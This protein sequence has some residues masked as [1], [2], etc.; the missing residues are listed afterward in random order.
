MRIVPAAKSK[1]RKHASN[2]GGKKSKDENIA[3]IIAKYS[4]LVFVSANIFLNIDFSPV[5]LVVLLV[6]VFIIFLLCV[7]LVSSGAGSMPAQKSA[8][9]ISDEK[10]RNALP[11]T[12]PPSFPSF[13]VFIETSRRRVCLSKPP[14]RLGRTARVETTKLCPQGPSCY[15][16]NEQLVTTK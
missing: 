15:Y 4:K 14:R 1:S 6:F 7:L 3:I 5:V 16:S 11:E 2:L 10:Q 8:A 9:Q 13:I 12:Y